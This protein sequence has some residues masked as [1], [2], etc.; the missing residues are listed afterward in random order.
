VLFLGVG[1]L[2]FSFWS[3]SE[4]LAKKPAAEVGIYLYLEPLFTM[5]GAAILI[6]EAI[7]VWVILGAGFIVAAVC[8]S[9]RFGRAK[10]VRHDL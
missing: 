1:C 5:T 2:A 7:T 3:W 9:E 4:G 8:I 10:L 6:G